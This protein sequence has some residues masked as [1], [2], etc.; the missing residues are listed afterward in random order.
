MLRRTGLRD[1]AQQHL[2]STNQRPV[3][4]GLGHKF[5]V[6]QAGRD[7]A[8]AA[9]HDQ[10]GLIA[11][12][13]PVVG[14]RRISAERAGEAGGEPVGTRVV[15]FQVQHDQIGTVPPGEFQPGSRLTCRQDPQ[16]AARQRTSPTNT[17]HSIPTPTHAYLSRQVPMYIGSGT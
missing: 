6:G 13:G 11:A 9:Q 4:I 10:P 7:A 2:D 8:E 3:V 5:P 1:G 14:T 15:E 16:S 12:G 17:R